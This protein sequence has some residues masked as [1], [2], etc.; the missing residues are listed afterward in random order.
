MGSRLAQA[1]KIDVSP[2]ELQVLAFM[3][4]RLRAG[5]PISA[6][7]CAAHGALPGF[8]TVIDWTRFEVHRLGGRFMFDG[9]VDVVAAQWTTLF[10]GESAPP[11]S[12]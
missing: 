11:R 2:S 8:R 3:S 6:V 12:S 7:V 5:L 4:V 9:V 1:K 10:S